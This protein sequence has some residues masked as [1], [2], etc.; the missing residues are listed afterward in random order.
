MEPLIFF[1]CCTVPVSQY[2]LFK[3]LLLTHK[4]LHNQ[5]PSYLTDLLHRHNPF[6]S[7]SSDAKFLTSPPR[8]KHRTWGD[9]AFSLAAPTLWNSLP[10]HICDCTN[11]PTFKSVTKTY[12]FKMA[13]K[14]QLSLMC[15]QCTLLYCFADFMFFMFIQ[16]SAFK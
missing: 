11:P 16:K 14:V 5:T 3:I 8:T 6:R 7:C 10:K 4:A 12:L 15:F 2:I 9:R 13:F 1:H